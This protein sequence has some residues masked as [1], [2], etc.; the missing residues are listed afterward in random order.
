MSKVAPNAT[1]SVEIVTCSTAS[2]FELFAPL[3]ASIDKHVDA[4]VHHKVVV[5]RA[6]L[7]MFAPLAS[8]R[9][10][11]IAQE[12]LLPS[13]LFKSPPFLKHLA[14]LRAGF[15][16][17]FYLTSKAQVVRGWMLQ[18]FLKIHMTQTSDAAAVLHVDSD[19]CFVRPFSAKDAFAD[20]KVTMFWVQGNTRN[21][22]HSDWVEG[23]CKFLGV[24]TPIEHKAHYIENCVMWSTDVARA[25]VKR[26]EDTHEKTLFDVIVEAETMSEYYLYGLFAD[27]FPDDA[28]L[29]REP[30]SYCNSYWPRSPGAAVST[31]VFM[32]RLQPKHCAV[33]V[34]STHKL[35]IE[36]RLKLYAALDDALAIS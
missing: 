26:I 1:Q 17:P 20:G 15:R 23:S 35:D 28:P 3:A 13:R 31:E 8:A 9:R 33:A 36:D 24:P 19:V 2:D 32:R 12:D 7:A 4:D 34:Q 25:M 11:V 6:D 21:P 22:K 10:S 30:V 5:P 18:Q 29:A 16:R 14:R 27:L